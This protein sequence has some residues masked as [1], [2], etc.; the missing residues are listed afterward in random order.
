[1]FHAKPSLSLL[2][3]ERTRARDNSNLS[4][5]GIYGQNMNGANSFLYPYPRRILE[6]IAE[7]C[8]TSDLIGISLMTCHFDNAVYITKFLREKLSVPIIW[9]GIHPSI[10]PAE[11]LEYADMVCLGEGE[12][13]LSQLAKEMAE[14]KP[15]NSLN[16]QGILKRSNPIFTASPVVEGSQ[17]DPLS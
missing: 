11:C 5:L 4:S 16:V 9:G 8:K 2:L 7:M 1:M 14:G 15:W 17:S 3:F 10:R 6:Q 13:S 12:L